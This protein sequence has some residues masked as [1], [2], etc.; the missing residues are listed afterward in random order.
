MLGHL[1]A[2]H[3]TVLALHRQRVWL[4]LRIGVLS[5]VLLYLLGDHGLPVRSPLG[6]II[7][8][9][10]IGLLVGLLLLLVAMM[11]AVTA[12]T[13]VTICRHFEASGE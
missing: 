9:G 3:H 11:T 6:L 2:G 1:Y 4:L 13:T 7:L 10:G 12:A 5:A 8:I